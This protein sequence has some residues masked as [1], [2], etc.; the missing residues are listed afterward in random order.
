[1]QTARGKDAD[2]VPH[3]WRRIMIVHF[4]SRRTTAM[5]SYAYLFLMGA[6]GA[7]CFSD[8]GVI[9]SI[10]KPAKILLYVFGAL[11][12]ISEGIALSK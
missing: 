7:Y 12:L 6:F 3:G 9:P 8:D 10:S 11:F 2:S 5:Q 1:M 4:L